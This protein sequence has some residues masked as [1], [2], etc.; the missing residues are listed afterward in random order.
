MGAHWLT[1]GRG[2]CKADS[3][4]QASE[5]ASYQVTRG[6]T[7]CSAPSAGSSTSYPDQCGYTAGFG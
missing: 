3:I 4:T 5:V 7:D 6:N 2:C 1:T